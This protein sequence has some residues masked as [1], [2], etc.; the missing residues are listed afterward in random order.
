MYSTP[1]TLRLSPVRRRISS[2]PDF[3]MISISRSICP[4]SSFMR[5]MGL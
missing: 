4:L 1:L 5:R 3:A 2:M